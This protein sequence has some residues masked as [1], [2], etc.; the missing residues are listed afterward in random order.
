M[1][2]ALERTEK[3][4]TVLRLMYAVSLRLGDEMRVASDSHMDQHQLLGFT[5]INRFAGLTQSDL[6]EH[7]HRSAVHVSRLVDELEVQGLVER[8]AHRFDRRSKDLHPTEKGTAVYARMRERSV[9]LA[10]EVFRET[11]KERLDILSQQAVRI[12]ERLH[13]ALTSVAPG[14]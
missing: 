6:A 5:L 1:D 13:L 9:Q 4:L 8:R 7:L 14:L 2:A 11:P 12:S 3:E 10:A